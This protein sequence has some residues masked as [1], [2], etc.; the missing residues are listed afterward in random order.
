MSR[1]VYPIQ[2]LNDLHNYFPD[3]LYNSG[4]FRNIQDLLGYIRQVADINPYT[5]GLNIYNTRTLND[6]GQNNVRIQSDSQPESRTEENTNTRAPNTRVPTNSSVLMS[7]L[8][9]NNGIFENIFGSVLEDTEH[10]TFLS[11]RV[12]INPTNEEINNASI[13]YR[14]VTSHD[15]ICTICQDTIELNQEIRKLNH[16]NHYFHSECIDVWFQTNVLCPT[17]RHD[18]REITNINQPS[19]V[20]NND[21]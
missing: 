5:Q 16:C 8:L 17:C 2:L 15:D 1:D 3:V 7:I 6:L 19:P 11:Q 12:N 4:R 20:S 14:A 21:R 9:S 18:I 13:I 10:Q